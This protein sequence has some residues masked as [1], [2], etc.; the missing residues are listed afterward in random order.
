MFS[1]HSLLLHTS[2]VVCTHS[3]C[4][5]LRQ[6]IRFFLPQSPKL[7]ALY[8]QFPTARTAL[9][10]EEI[11]NSAGELSQR[12]N[13]FVFLSGAV[14]CEHFTLSESTKHEVKIVLVVP[15]VVQVRN[16]PPFLVLS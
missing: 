9:R 6:P 14:R 5:I 2:A 7:F 12:R 15:A 11:M 8:P 4:Q 16:I 10:K 13:Y 1:F 3:G